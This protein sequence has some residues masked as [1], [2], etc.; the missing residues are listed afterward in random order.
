MTRILVQEEINTATAKQEIL[1]TE[2]VELVWITDNWLKFECVMEATGTELRSE[3]IGPIQM[4]Y[5]V[6]LDIYG[7]CL[8]PRRHRCFR[9]NPPV[10]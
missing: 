2:L 4:A 5:L 3:P 8:G 9:S 1:T 10:W 6:W 7:T